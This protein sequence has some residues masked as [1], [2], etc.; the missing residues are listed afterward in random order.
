MT[1]VNL[2]GKQFTNYQFQLQET[3]KGS[4]IDSMIS[5]LSRM[6]CFDCPG[7]YYFD[8]DQTYLVFA[9]TANFSKKNEETGRASYYLR[10]DICTRTS[11]IEKIKSREIKKLQRLARRRENKLKRFAERVSTE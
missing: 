3:F 4:T 9:N 5:I 6:G 2:D 11:I 7:S 10:T 8:G 1:D